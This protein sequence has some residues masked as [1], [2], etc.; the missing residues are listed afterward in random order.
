M[1]QFY[2][3]TGWYL[4]C[5][6]FD[7]DKVCITLFLEKLLQCY[8]SFLQLIIPLPANID[9]NVS[10]TKVPENIMSVLLFCIVTNAQH[11]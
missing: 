4:D 1:V 6:L 5:T 10:T 11:E 8:D 9:N 7:V 3:V 2:Y